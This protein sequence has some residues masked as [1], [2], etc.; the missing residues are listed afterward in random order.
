MLNVHHP[1]S[2]QFLCSVLSAKDWPNSIGKEVAFWGKSNV[3]KSSLLNAL[4]QRKNLAKVSKTPGRTQTINFYQIKNKLRY[5][6]LPGYGYACVSKKIQNVWHQHVLDYLL[7]RN[8]LCFVC[9]LVDSKRDIHPQDLQVAD[10][11]QKSL[12]S[13]QWI[14]TKIDRISSIQRQNLELNVKKEHCLEVSALT[15][16]GIV[17]LRSYINHSIEQK[18][19]G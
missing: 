19:C 17:E 9:I 11:L 6:D 2:C 10:F 5:V 15:G 12:V 14:Y 18:N 13:V 1:S 7:D 16:Q 8:N 3:G 4:M